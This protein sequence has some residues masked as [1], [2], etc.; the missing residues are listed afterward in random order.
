MLLSTQLVYAEVK[1]N[2]KLVTAL[3]DSGAY[4]NVISLSV[5]KELC[6]CDPGL[7]PTSLRCASVAARKLDVLGTIKL[8]TR[9]SNF[10]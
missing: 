1:I 10:P 7:K 4:V 5:L 3:L 6:G 9:I 2:Q 8:K